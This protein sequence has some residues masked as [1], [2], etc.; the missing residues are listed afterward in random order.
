MHPAEVRPATAWVRRPG[1]WRPRGPGRP[2]GPA[3]ERRGARE[4]RGR[5][6]GPAPGAF[7][8]GGGAV[9]RTPQ[10]VRNDDGPPPDEP[11]FD[12]DYDKPAGN[13][14]YD[15]FDPGDEPLDDEAEA[16]L[17][18]SEEQALRLLAEKLGAEKIGEAPAR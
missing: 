11:P 12:P 7:G 4:R 13:G 14:F 16:A 3:G 9:G 18:T 6:G 8:V 5:R 15:G 1:R 2:R 17:G 10:N